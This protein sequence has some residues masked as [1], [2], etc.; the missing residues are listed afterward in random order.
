L[1]CIYGQL[2][3]CLCHLADS[4]PTASAQAAR[5]AEQGRAQT[6][7]GILALE[8]REP[9]GCDPAEY[10]IYLDGEN[11]L[12]DLDRLLDAM[13]AR[14]YELTQ[15]DP[16]RRARDRRLDEIRTRRA[17]Q[18]R[19][20][21]EAREGLRRIDPEW[22]PAA[23]PMGPEAIQD[24]ARRAGATLLTIQAT[25]QGTAVV[26]VP[27][28]GPI[29][30]QLFPAVTL[31]TVGDWLTGKSG[32][33]KAYVVA[34]ATDPYDAEEYAARQTDW[35][36][37]LEGTMGRAG[38][39]LWRSVLDWL[40]G[41]DRPLDLDDPPTVIV[42]AGPLMA[43]VPHH[44]AWWPVGEEIRRLSDELALSYVPSA[45]LLRE[46]LARRE[47]LSGS[48]PSLLATRNPTGHCPGY[49]LV[50]TEHEADQVARQFPGAVVL[51]GARSP[52][53][54]PA[55]RDR[56]IS[57]L[58]KHSVALLATHGVFDPDSP[59]TGSGLLTADHSP[60]DGSRPQLTLGDLYDLSLENLGLIAVTACESSRSEL[61]DPTGDQL[62]LPS[63]L[64][65]SGATCV[66]GS[67]W[68]I[69]DL[70]VALLSPRFFREAYPGA[71]SGRVSHARALR[72][73]Q[74]WL[75]TLTRER[76]LRLLDAIERSLPDPGPQLRSMPGESLTLSRLHTRAARLA[77]ERRGDFPFCHPV[78]WA[79]L[80]CY[81][82]P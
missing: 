18:F 3:A 14:A 55:T 40:L 54:Q 41:P 72:L 49:E 52:G 9:K 57:E 24:I 78:Y 6:L 42:M 33:L 51:G 73:A 56:L 58:P 38:V 10:Q 37:C 25:G 59:W 46:C 81:G 76:A 32:L 35:H 68:V 45:R 15:T 79:A 71:D 13:E 27:P 70:A 80:S 28:D 5:W 77:L 47:R 12:R 60:G 16:R 31:E 82:V 11:E 19:R 67:S 66:V 17:Q 1:P 53:Y 62:G 29:R 74:I 22:A 64:L 34:Q 69:D 48:R 44:V 75:R 20:Q 7:A 4:D 21:L 23:D 65:V 43:N 63:A 26:A 50:W 2:L 61:A 30:A 36:T 8:S 39:E